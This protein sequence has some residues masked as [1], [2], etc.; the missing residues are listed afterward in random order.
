MEILAI[1]GGGGGDVTDNALGRTKTMLRVLKQ[2][3]GVCVYIW[4]VH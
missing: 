1:Y 4:L 2:G 3:W